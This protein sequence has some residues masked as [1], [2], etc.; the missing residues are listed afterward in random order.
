MTEVSVAASVVDRDDDCEVLCISVELVLVGINDEEES[1]LEELLSEDDEEMLEEEEDEFSLDT[2]DSEL[3]L[4]SIVV[5]LLETAEDAV[6]DSENFASDIETLDEEDA[7]TV[8]YVPIVSIELELLICVHDEELC[9]SEDETEDTTIEVK[10]IVELL[11]LAFSSCTLL[12]NCCNVGFTENAN[13]SNHLKTNIFCRY[14][15]YR[16]KDSMVK[17]MFS[18]LYSRSEWKI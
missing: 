15:F 9:T 2:I 13:N 17:A 12:V 8:E 6:F 18:Q 3:V 1:A 5:F 11:E 16:E 4:C 14:L 10:E 7:I